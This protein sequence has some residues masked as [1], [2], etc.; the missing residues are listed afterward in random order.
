MSAPIN[1]LTGRRFGKLTVL[2]Y[3]GERGTRHYWR[4]VCDCG[5]EKECSGE[6][7]LYA[8]VT[9]CGCARKSPLAFNA[10]KVVT[11]EQRAWLERHFRNTRNEEIMERF[12]WSHSFLHRLARGMGLKKTGRFQTKCQRNAADKAKES[13]IIHGTFPPKGYIIPGS[14]RYRFKS[15]ETSLQ[16]LGA[17]KERQRLEKSAETRRRLLKEEKARRTF[18]VP[19][20]TKLRVRNRG[21]RFHLNTWYLRSRGYEVDVNNLVAY[22]NDKTNRCPLLEKK[23]RNPDEGHYFDFREKAI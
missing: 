15:G 3:A 1:D 18:G 22:W 8:G 19:Q 14:E 5:G 12:G 11:D 16:R 7:M 13:H 2:S 10:K 4:V 17:R 9:S 6:S 20:Q 23:G 21:R